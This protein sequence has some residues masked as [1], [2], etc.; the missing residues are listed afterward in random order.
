[1]LAP[2]EQLSMD[3]ASYGSSKYLV[4]KD[5]ASGFLAVENTKDQTTSEALK[6]TH[7]WCFTYGL[8]HSIRSDDGPAFRQGFTDYLTGLG[9]EHK[10]SSAYNPS[11]NGLAERGVRQ[12]KDVLKKV[13][14]PSGEKLRELIFDINNH[15][16]PQQGSASERFFRRGPRTVLPNSIKREVEHRSLIKARHQ[17]QEKI[18]KNKGRTSKDIFKE[19]DKV[20]LQNPKTKRWTEY[21]TVNLRRTAD[22]GSH[23]SFEIQLD[24]GGSALRNKRFMKHAAQTLRKQVSFN[25]DADNSESSGPTTR[26]RAKRSS[27]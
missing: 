16:Q 12:L 5:R 6:G 2:G 15:Q 22:D 24:T 9:I 3:Y 10:N 18:S 11:S 13:K 4:I 20:V 19:G 27:T 17:K 8:P 23:Q 25:L 26:L 21:G 1:M 14:K 7:K